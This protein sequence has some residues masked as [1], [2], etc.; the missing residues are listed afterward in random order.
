MTLMNAQAAEV[1]RGFTG[2]DAPEKMMQLQQAVNSTRA[3]YTSAAM[4]GNKFLVENRNI[5]SASTSFNDALEKQKVR[6]R[7]VVGNMRVVRQAYKEQIALANMSVA[8]WSRTATGKTSITM[9][10]PNTEEI[11]RLGTW[12]TALG[13]STRVVNSLSQSVINLGKNIQ[14]SG[15]QLMVGFTVPVGIAAAATGKLAYDMDSSVTKIMKVYDA[16]AD[17]IRMSNEQIRDQAVRTSKAMAAAYGQSS[18]DTMDIMQELAA[19][20]KTGE[21]LEA[22]TRSIT[23]A[24]LAGDLDIQTALKTNIT[25]QSAYDLSTKKLADT[26]AFFNS[27]ENSTVLT[28]QDISEAIPRVA[29]LMRAA[30]VSIEDTTV[31]LTAFKS[32]GIDA[33]EGATALKSIATRVIAPRKTAREGFEALT[34]IDYQTVLDKTKGELMPTLKEI[35]ELTKD[36]SQQERVGL[37]SQLIG[38]HQGSR[39]AGLLTQLGNLSDATTQ[40][41]RAAQVAQQ[42]SSEWTKT[43]NGEL[44]TL[45]KS[46]SNRLKRAFEEAKVDLAEIGM[47]VLKM[48][49]PLAEGIASFIKWFNSLDEGKKKVALFAVGIV[50]AFGPLVM[51]AG[52]TLNLV[53]TFF[54]MAGAIVGLATSFKILKPESKAAQ[55]L[56]EAENKAMSAGIP[57]LR[58][59]QQEH[60][61]L[62]E[63]IK[64]Q[65]QAIREQLELYPLLNAGAPGGMGS[66]RHNLRDPKTGLYVSRAEYD[67]I[68]AA[69]AAMAN[70]EKSSGK[71]KGHM[72]GAA[73]SAALM[74]GMF[75]SNEWVSN[76]ANVTFMAST[77]GPYLLKS[78]AAIPYI[79]GIKNLWGGVTTRIGKAGG[80]VGKLKT[81]VRGLGT[82]MAGPWGLAVGA[83]LGGVL[84][85]IKAINDSIAETDARLKHANE[86]SQAWGKA[87]GFTVKDIKIKPPVEPK[88]LDNMAKMN[89]AVKVFRKNNEDAYTELSKLA[90]NGATDTEKWQK[91]IEEGLKVR[92]RGGTVDEAKRVVRVALRI[93]GKEFDSSK[94]F[95]I[96]IKPKID[97]KDPQRQIDERAKA[98]QKA[99]DRAAQGKYNVSWQEDIGRFFTESSHIDQPT[100]K[101]MMWDTI[102]SAGRR[103]IKSAVAE[104]MKTWTQV[105]EQEGNEAGRKVL[106]TLVDKINKYFYGAFKKAQSEGRIDEGMSFDAFMNKLLGDSTGRYAESLGIDTKY[107]SAYAQA[108]DAASGKLELANKRDIITGRDLVDSAM[109][110]VDANKRKKTAIDIATAASQAGLGVAQNSATANK[111][112]A[113]ELNNLLESRKKDTRSTKEWKDALEQANKVIDTQKEIMT[114]VQGTMFDRLSTLAERHDEDE[115]AR[116]QAWE[117]RRAQALQNKY[118]RLQDGVDARADKQNEALD[119]RQDRI[120][121]Q[122]DKRQEAMEARFDEKSDRLDAAFD[123]RSE[124]LDAKFDAQRERIDRRRER[125]DR[126]FENRWDAIS[127]RLEQRQEARRDAIAKAFDDRIDKINKEIEAEQRAEEKRQKI[128]E[129]EKARIS[130]MAEMFNQNVDFNVAVNSGN[131]DDAAK[132]AN[133]MKANE[134]SWAMDDVADQSQTAS[135]RRVAGYQKEID[136]INKAKDARLDRLEKV[137]EAEKDALDRRRAR[138]EREVKYARAAEDK[139]FDA[140]RDA[141]H[142]RLDMERDAAQKRLDIARDNAA[143]VIDKERETA[144]K[145]IDIQRD[146]IAKAAEQEKKALE[147]SLARQQRK[148]DKENKAHGRMIEDERTRRDAALQAELDALR[149]HIPKNMKQLRNQRDA[150]E[151]IYDKYGIEMG[152]KEDK[153]TDLYRDLIIQKTKEAKN[154][155]RD[156][157]SW[158][159]VGKKIADRMLQGSMKMNANEA[160]RFLM[161]GKL[162]PR[163]KRMFRSDRTTGEK[164]AGAKHRDYAGSVYHTGGI[165]GK[166]AG[167]RVGYQRDSARQQSEVDTRL[168]VG[169]GVLNRRA[170]SRPGM[171]DLV[172][173]ANEGKVTDLTGDGTPRSGFAAGPVANFAMNS[174]APEIMSGFSLLMQQALA[175]QSAVSAEVSGGGLTAEQRRNASIILGVGKGMGATKR[176]LV[177]S[178][179]TAMQESTLRNLHYGDRDSLGLFQQRPSAGWGTPKQITNPRYASAKFFQALLGIPNRDELSLAGA[180]Q[181]VQRSAFPSAYAKWADLARD[182]VGGARFGAGGGRGFG[183]LSE[184]NMQAVLKAIATGGGGMGMRTANGSWQNLWRIVKSHF[185]NAILTSAY[186]PGARVA[187]YGNYS[188]H[189]MGRAIDIAPNKKIWNWLKRNFGGSSHELLGPWGMYRDGKPWHSAITAAN[190]QDHIHWALTNGGKIPG[191]EIGGK[192]LNT[193]LARLHPDEMVLTKPLTA[194][195]ES[196]IERI[197]EGAHVEYNV[198]VNLNGPVS[199]DFNHREFK[200]NIQKVLREIEQE[201]GPRRRI[202]R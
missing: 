171:E 201:Q 6:L 43:F 186:R 118:D 82:F 84:L 149:A 147:K 168:L 61:E 17:G 161:T 47:V 121:K 179:M 40:V 182:V 92:L 60:V 70:T 52:L 189:A 155:V 103:E 134:E 56:A 13:Y 85:G 120:D 146:R 173:L 68:I 187:G 177:V 42:D 196:G 160:W 57:I 65:S 150:A 158:D 126:A 165:V 193:G 135:D 169:E 15:R 3:A 156:D 117:E 198:E 78:K 30:G 49:T 98:V 129:A 59:Q 74:V 124:K 199:N 112:A 34:G 31:L 9:A 100:G 114:D 128:F 190:H 192:T 46:L 90:H 202:S 67:K 87:L 7:D 176:D 19:A 11:K 162:P 131:L 29:G 38:I 109:A 136:A 137:E 86:S 5:T 180:A 33:V 172:R 154:H 185:P 96:H 139:K 77:I 148:M 89:N 72:A 178:I 63:A 27:I 91:A 93:M 153:W 175:R 16:G 75:S 94:D 108:I 133:D 55:I 122:L 181:A 79:A 39:F 174:M 50:A 152:K 95:E 58:R 36:L 62:A 200:R 188:M 66:T 53:G 97:F 106:Q 101:R 83:A 184:L 28:M 1:S 110:Q 37:I 2:M 23:K 142:K 32:A 167:G 105:T 20:G 44:E 195:L 48:I 144:R 22:Q 113:K 183:G 164:R 73:A 116:R 26:W 21:D 76:I 54:R 104:T 12:R 138:A 191:L 64:L 41:G 119:R 99:L 151:K 102:N 163:I 81:G 132:I 197:D 170:M 159:K 140:Q 111:D 143:A 69:E 166:S 14:W 123:A 125:E 115:D 107:L 71:L 24:A 51:L 157:Q 141:A 8:S 25:L 145:Q 127:D 194:K 80:M 4:A 35:A 10:V 130:N 18:K 88:D 45:R